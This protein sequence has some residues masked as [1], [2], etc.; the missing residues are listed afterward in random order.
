MGFKRFIILSFALTLIFSLFH[1]EQSQAPTGSANLTSRESQIVALV[2]GT[3][4]YSYDLEL[5]KIALNHSVSHYS[6]RSSGSAGANA[7]AL[8]LED[9]FASFG[10]STSLESFEFTNWNMLGQPALI[11]DEDGV[12]GTISDQTLISSF[13]SAH[14]SWPTSG[15]GVFADLVVLP[16]P[17]AGRYSEI[18][19]QQ[20]N[21]TLWDSIDTLDK[22]VLI[23]GEVR[24][25][26]TWEQ[27]FQNKLSSQPP[28]AVICTWWYSWMSFAPPFLSSV[29]G[30]PTSSVG[31]YLW[32]YEIPCGWVDY[33]DGEWVRER[34]DHANVS[35][36]VVI[37]SVIASGPHYNVVGKLQRSVVSDKLVIVS[38]HYDTVLTAGFVD[39]GAGT[40]GILEL[41]QVL[42][43]AYKEGFYNPNCTVVF[44]AFAGEELGLVGAV[45]YV[46][47]HKAEI[48]DVIAVINLDCIGSDNLYV[49]KTDS[50]PD[51]DLDQLVLDSADDLN[52]AAVLADSGGSD[53]EVFRNPSYAENGFSYWWPGLSAGIDDAIPIASS[54]MLISYPLSYSDARIGGEPGWIHTSYD[55]STST[56]TLDWLEVV[57]LEDHV[58]VAALSVVRISSSSQE[59]VKASGFPWWIV[60]VAVAGV[61]AAI[62]VTIV[63]V[64]KFR[65]RSVKQLTESTLED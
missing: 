28:A 34:E 63:Y 46:K 13:Q 33:R 40:A 14:F 58:K 26:S 60:G 7:T 47:Q 39:N 62:G 20:I 53:H 52:V 24:W 54:T 4:A 18:G 6:F 36:K 2:N 30:R 41:A 55:N 27:T 37:P 44:V 8:W 50:G 61:M 51:F 23:G 21:T 42:T 38:A 43:Y 45:N 3:R 16:L 22:I 59:T 15:S 12:T 56:Q 29:G 1:N 5:E 9:Q 32:N 11:I 49:A 57:S 25:N 35:A 19:R 65:K 64:F 17:D 10:L 48:K 31:S